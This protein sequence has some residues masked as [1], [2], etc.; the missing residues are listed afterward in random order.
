MIPLAGQQKKHRR[1]EQTLGHS[2]E[3]EGGV[4]WESSIETYT[5]PYVK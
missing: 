5:L 3:A 4:T 1:K 2:G